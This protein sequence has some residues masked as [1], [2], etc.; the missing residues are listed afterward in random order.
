ML[1]ESKHIEVPNSEPFLTE[2]HSETMAERC[3]QFGTRKYRKETAELIR[4]AKMAQEVD[5]EKYVKY[6][7]VTSGVSAQK[8]SYQTWQNI[9][10]NQIDNN[11]RFDPTFQRI[12]V[13]EKKYIS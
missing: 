12:F 4:E 13:T 3:G 7:K 5:Q 9:K 6:K 8:S 2:V 10:L 11:K 1:R